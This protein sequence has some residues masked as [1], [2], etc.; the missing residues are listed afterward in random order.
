M[1]C[2]APCCLI[3]PFI[4]LPSHSICRLRAG[5]RPTLRFACRQPLA[6]AHNALAV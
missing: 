5:R 6:T 1:P 4:L 2:A 3:T